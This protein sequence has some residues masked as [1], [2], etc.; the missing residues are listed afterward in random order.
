MILIVKHLFVEMPSLCLAV[1]FVLFCFLCLVVMVII[2]LF[3]LLAFYY[4]YTNNVGVKLL[5]Q[6]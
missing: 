5:V 4:S 1:S 6:L 3:F 2:F